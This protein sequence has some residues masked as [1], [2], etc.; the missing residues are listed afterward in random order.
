VKEKNMSVLDSV[1]TT[2]SGAM[3]KQLAGQ[4]G[5]TPDQASSSVSALLPAL[6]AGMKEKLASGDG[7]GLSQ[8]ISSGSLTKFA[9]NPSSLA[10]PAAVEQGKS[11]LSQIFGSQDLSSLVSMVAEK[12]G[13]GSSVITSLLPV[14]ATLLGGLLSK[15]SAAGGNI[16]DMIGQFASAGH[17]GV[18]DTVK[19]LAAKIF[20]GN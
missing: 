11:L 4:F 8:L 13:V 1:L 12:A 17:S 2:G 14:G 5:I 3:V 20:G 7:S 9:D 18:I 15:S 16:T 10:T 19:V 6:A